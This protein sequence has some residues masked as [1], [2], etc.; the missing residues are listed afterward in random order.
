MGAAEGYLAGAAIVEQSASALH[1]CEVELTW[2]S[3]PQVAIL[4]RLNGMTSELHH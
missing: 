3:L 2:L 1:V 4:L